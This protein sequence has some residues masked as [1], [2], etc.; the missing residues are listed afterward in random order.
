MSI[1]NFKNN[2]SYDQDKIIDLLKTVKIIYERLSKD[3]YHYAKE[4]EKFQDYYQ[5]YDLN[6][7]IMLKIMEEKLNKIL[8]LFFVSVKNHISITTNVKGIGERIIK[9]VKEEYGTTTTIKYQNICKICM[10]DYNF[11]NGDVNC[12]LS[13]SRF[14]GIGNILKVQSTINIATY[15]NISIEKY[16]DNCTFIGYIL[17]IG[18]L[19]YIIGNFNMV[20]KF[21]THISCDNQDNVSSCI[22]NSSSTATAD[23]NK[24][25]SNIIES[26][27][28]FVDQQIQTLGDIEITLTTNIEYANKHINKFQQS[29]KNCS[30]KK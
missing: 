23:N 16:Y 27:F 19:S 8:H 14:S 28:L 26:L 6:N 12:S 4:L 21:K 2:C 7:G 1:N 22:T 18:K 20:K 24:I 29:H 13:K 17:T 25:T 5:R 3:V 30:C 11:N 9:P 15:D 10:S